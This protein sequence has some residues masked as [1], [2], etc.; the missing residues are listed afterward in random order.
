M[1]KEKNNYYFLVSVFIGNAIVLMISSILLPDL[2]VFGNAYL[3]SLPAVFIVSLLLTFTLMLV[4][5]VLKSIKM[6]VK[7]AIC[8]N[9]IYCFV[10][11][12]AIWIL[13]RFANF[14]GFGISSY[15]AAIFMGAVITTIQ[16]LFWLRLGKK[17]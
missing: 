9:L 14:F 3:S 12:L 4:P 5:K 17:N 16:Y 8:I 10:N 1:K 6:K 11:I 15:I 2:I 7:S 13:A